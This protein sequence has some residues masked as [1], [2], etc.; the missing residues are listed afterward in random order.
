MNK[1]L[2]LTVTTAIIALKSSSVFAMDEDRPTEYVKST[3][4]PAI[5]PNQFM[6]PPHINAWRFDHETKAMRHDGSLIPRL[7]PVPV[8]NIVH[9]AYQRRAKD[10]ALNSRDW[11][12]TKNPHGMSETEAVAHLKKELSDKTTA[13]A[14]TFTFDITQNLDPNY[15]AKFDFTSRFREVAVITLWSEACGLAHKEYE[16]TESPYSLELERAFREAEKRGD[17]DPLKSARAAAL[18]FIQPL[19]PAADDQ[20]S[21]L[22]QKFLDLWDIS[23]I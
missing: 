1:F 6:A 4:I 19:P 16:C 14:K 5:F 21:S 12:W 13:L 3:R 7:D 20:P 17:R 11:V 8:E 9:E 18:R 2:L 10:R 23:N 15:R 22:W